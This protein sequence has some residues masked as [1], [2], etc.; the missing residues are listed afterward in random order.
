MTGAANPISPPVQPPPSTGLQ[1]RPHDALPHGAT[2]QNGAYRIGQVLGRGGFGITYFGADTHLKRPVAI[3]ELFPQQEC[4]RSASQVVA[5]PNSSPATLQTARQQFIREA[6]T[7]ARFS[8]LGI[9]RV[10]SVFAENSTAYMVMELLRGP[11]LWT[12]IEQSGPFSETE[13]ASALKFVGEALLTVHAAGT[14]HRDINPSN[15]INCGSRMVL[16]DFGLTQDVE[17]ATKYGTRALSKTA[18]F[19]TE[20]FAPIEQYSSGG[21]SQPATDIYALGATLYFL[22]T[23]RV[24]PAA[25]SRAAGEVLAAPRQIDPRISEPFSDAVLWAMKM[26]IAERP[27]SVEQWLAGWASGSVSHPNAN[28]VVTSGFAGH[29]SGTSALPVSGANAS[30]SGTTANSSANSVGGSNPAQLQAALKAVRARL[31]V[32]PMTKED[33]TAPQGFTV[34]TNA[35]LDPAWLSNSHSHLPTIVRLSARIIDW[36]FECA[37]CSDDP[38]ARFFSGFVVKRGLR[39]MRQPTD[40][41]LVPLCTRCNEHYALSREATRWKER[42]QGW[43]QHAAQ[44]EATSAPVPPAPIYPQPPQASPTLPA[45]PPLP[46]KPVDITAGSVVCKW[47]F[48]VPCL[49]I[50]NFIGDDF[51]IALVITIV[52]A[53]V[54]IPLYKG[55]NWVYGGEK[56]ESWTRTVEEM[57][58][59]HEEEVQRYSQKFAED[60]AQRERQYQQQVQQLQSDYAREV[61]RLQ[62]EHAQAI[63][64]AHY[65]TQEAAFVAGELPKLAAGAVGQNCCGA[66]PCVIHADHAGSVHTFVFWNAQFGQR[67]AEANRGK[68]LFNERRPVDFT[69]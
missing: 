36:P 41:W 52:S 26:D 22:L 2:L 58:Q 50:W 9:V 51:F 45:M 24:P 69:A 11:S 12:Q 25:P 6:Q 13:A 53:G 21:L 33:V 62:D 40:Q 39:V 20:G 63:R 31:A 43:R 42:I 54:L 65:R 37:C 15:I 14:L 30:G 59:A 5:A 29:A 44:L 10:H 35:P 18:S 4:R 28:P 48:Y 16:I 8:H 32:A 46:S 60:E 34:D 19:G 17:K 7:L 56:Q 1:P 3:K 27:Q 57:K 47:W 49:L 68:V 67:F 64:E 55:I 38:D 61:A 66:D 23:G